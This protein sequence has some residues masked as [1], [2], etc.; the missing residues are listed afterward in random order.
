LGSPSN[1]SP[2]SWAVLGTGKLSEYGRDPIGYLWGI[3][4]IKRDAC[5]IDHLAFPPSFLLSFLSSFSP[6]ACPPPP[7]SKPRTP[8]LLAQGPVSLLTPEKHPRAL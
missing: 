7:P 4:C 1:S 6:F 2:S 8:E 5:I 3:G